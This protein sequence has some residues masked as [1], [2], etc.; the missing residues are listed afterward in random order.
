MHTLQTGTGVLS[1]TAFSEGYIC[2]SYVAITGLM[3]VQESDIIII[4]IIYFILFYN[5]NA[6]STVHS[7][8]SY[9]SWKKQKQKVC[10]EQ[11]TTTISK[12]MKIVFHSMNSTVASS[13]SQNLYY[14]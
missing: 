14:V 3:N 4:I 5:R 12:V 9:R 6:V 7:R 8:F 1:L 2:Q 11:L 10:T 13:T